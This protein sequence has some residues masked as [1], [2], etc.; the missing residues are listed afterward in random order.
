MNIYSNQLSINVSIYFFISLEYLSF[1]ITKFSRK[2][3]R[4]FAVETFHK[5]PETS[6]NC[7]EVS[8]L[9]FKFLI[10]KSLKQ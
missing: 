5:F 4:N 8:N 2:L 9:G 10:K 1:W 7:L 6:G 3:S